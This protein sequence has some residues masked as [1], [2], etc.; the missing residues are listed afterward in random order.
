M[1]G[2]PHDP[3]LEVKLSP[4]RTSAAI[5]S[6]AMPTFFSFSYLSIESIRLLNPALVWLVT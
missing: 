6:P 2:I 1:K 3:N 5:V 4:A